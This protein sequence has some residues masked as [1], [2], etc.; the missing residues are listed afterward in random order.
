VT[1]LAVLREVSEETVQPRQVTA[2][3]ATP[4]IRSGDVLTLLSVSRL[5]SV[6]A[7]AR[8][9]DTTPSQVSKAVVRLE[10]RLSTRLLVRTSRGTR[11]TEAG[12]RML[13]HLE[14]IA[15]RTRLLLAEGAELPSR[16]RMAAPSSLSRCLLHRAAAAVEDW[17]L[18]LM[19]MSEAAIHLRLS[20]N[21]FDIALTSAEHELPKAW[22][23]QHVGELRH[24]VFA[25]P[26]L[27]SRWPSGRVGVEELQRVPCITPVPEGGA[28]VGRLDDQCPLPLESRRPGH[29]AQTLALAFDLAAVSDQW[30]FAPVISA[31]GAVESGRLVEAPVEG[32]DVRSPLLLLCAAERVRASS[33]RA[34]LGAFRR[35]LHDLG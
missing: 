33:L 19:E 26:G 24:A 23:A 5:G 15:H 13:P 10:A 14:A 32:W 16:L 17:V 6:T 12:A 8:E 20:D 35:A 34:I 30:V 29:Q 11:L 2:G 18:L 22:S 7:A 27:V 31:R 9:L 3:A 1:P 21:A 25:R 4:D 28:Y